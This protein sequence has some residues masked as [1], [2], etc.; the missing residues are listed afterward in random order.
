[1]AD[2]VWDGGGDGLGK[3]QMVVLM[4]VELASTPILEAV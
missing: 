4:V 3:V 1:M 2:G